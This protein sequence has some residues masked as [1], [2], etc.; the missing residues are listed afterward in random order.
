MD[1]QYDQAISAINA[2]ERAVSGELSRRYS[3]PAAFRQ[4][5]TQALHAQARLSDRLFNELER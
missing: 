4:A 1:R 3:T 5:L 2:D